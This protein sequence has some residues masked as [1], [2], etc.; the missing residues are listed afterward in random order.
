MRRDE[1]IAHR[2]YSHAA[3]ELEL[4]VFND[5]AVYRAYYL[6]VCRS[7]ARRYKDGTF[8]RDLALRSMRRCADAAAKQYRLEHGSMTSKWNEMFPTGDRDRVAETLVDHLLDALRNGE[9]FW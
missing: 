8:N 2:K 7:L 6:P 9:A 4:Y 3:V 5:S 1:I